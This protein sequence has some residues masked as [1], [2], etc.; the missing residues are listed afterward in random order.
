LYKQPITDRIVKSRRLRWAGHATKLGGKEWIKKFGEE[1]CWEWPILEDRERGKRI[2]LRWILGKHVD[3]LS[4]DLPISKEHS[5][6][7]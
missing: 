7:N 1:S 2:V 6:F 4:Q 5:C 3:E